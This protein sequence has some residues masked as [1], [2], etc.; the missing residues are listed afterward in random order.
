MDTKCPWV[1]HEPLNYWAAALLLPIS[2]VFHWKYILEIT[3]YQKLE[4]QQFLAVTVFGRIF[5]QRSCSVF[6]SWFEAER[7]YSQ[8][9]NYS[10]Y[11]SRRWL[12]F[13]A[14][15]VT[16]VPERLDCIRWIRNVNKHSLRT[17]CRRMKSI[18]CNIESN[19][20]K[21]MKP[22]IFGSLCGQRWLYSTDW[23]VSCEWMNEIC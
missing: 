4:H 5:S 22:L 19:S 2:P 6:W 9:N 23:I 13:I 18:P 17:Q 20:L 11:K 16:F 3:M 10:R 12:E 21:A 7:F 14:V 1:E 8:N 15:I